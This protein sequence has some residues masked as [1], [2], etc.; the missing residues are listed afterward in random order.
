[1]KKLLPLFIL[2]FAFGVSAQ[3]Y[4]NKNY[5]FS[6]ALPKDFALVEKDVSGYLAAFRLGDNYLA[7][8]EVGP[9]DTTNEQL[10]AELKSESSKK[11]FAEQLLAGFTPEQ[12]AKVV[13]NNYLAFN[14]RPAAQIGYE[15][16]FKNR[17]TNGLMVV[18]F[19]EEKKIII[20]F[21][22][23]SL[24]GDALD[25]CREAIKSLKIVKP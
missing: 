20:G 19:V 14:G 3:E 8:T 1:M 5:G 17:P 9:L 10:S 18:M 7:I 24:S 12:K 13:S 11:Y 25:Y 15:A 6:V 21:N 4:V 2:I 16:L 23:Y 22:C